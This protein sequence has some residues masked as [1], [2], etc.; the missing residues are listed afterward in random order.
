MLR[1]KRIQKGSQKKELGAR[2]LEFYAFLSYQKN[3]RESSAV[4]LDRHSLLLLYSAKSSLTL[5]SHSFT[6]ELYAAR[7]IR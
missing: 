6:P 7:L 2:I 3:C 1:K 4:S 5:F